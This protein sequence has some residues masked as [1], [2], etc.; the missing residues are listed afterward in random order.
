MIFL[1]Q[2]DL[3][4]QKPLLLDQP[5]IIVSTPSRAVLHLEAANLQ[6]KDTLEMLI[7]DEA[8]LMFS[9]GHENYMDKVL[10]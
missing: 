10:K 8:D 1:L 5:N 3:S 9:V 4:V 7:I 6:I 2:V